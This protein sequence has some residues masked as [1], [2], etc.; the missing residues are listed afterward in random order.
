MRVLS[1]ALRA[2][3]ETQRRGQRPVRLLLPGDSGGCSVMLFAFSSC[4]VR[5]MYQYDD[6]LRGEGDREPEPGCS[7]LRSEQGEPM[8][9]PKTHTCHIRSHVRLLG[10]SS[11]L[12]VCLRSGSSVHL[13]SGWGAQSSS[14]STL[15]HPSDCFC[16]GPSPLITLVT[17]RSSLGSS[18]GSSNDSTVRT[19]SSYAKI[20]LQYHAKFLSRFLETIPLYFRWHG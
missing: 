3:R 15:A 13:G 17:S 19:A 16:P 18:E 11:R 10:L 14:I 8:C 1:L 20:E 9:R 2:C 4:F 6:I 7:N 5:V 12:R